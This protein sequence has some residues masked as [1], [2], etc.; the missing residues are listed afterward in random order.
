MKK[1]FE[2]LKNR[3]NL[4]PPFQLNFQGLYNI[5]SVIVGILQVLLSLLFIGFSSYR[6]YLF[7]YSLRDVLQIYDNFIPFDVIGA[8]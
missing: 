4:S 8:L 6:S 2:K 7:I 1:I 3:D 5:Q